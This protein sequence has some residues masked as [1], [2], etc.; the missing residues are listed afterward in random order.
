MSAAAADGTG[1][2]EDLRGAERQ[3]VTEL[4]ANVREDPSTTGRSSRPYRRLPS[5]I[6]PPTGP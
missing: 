3:E 2:S 1:C 4:V 5:G 6:T